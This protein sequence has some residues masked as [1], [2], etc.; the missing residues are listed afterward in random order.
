MTAWARDLGNVFKTLPA[1]QDYVMKRGLA[2]GAIGRANEVARDTYDIF[3]KAPPRIGRE[4]FS[5]LTTAGATVA[6][7]SDPRFHAAA[8]TTKRRI[9]VIGRTLVARGVITQA[10][11]DTYKDAYL[12][13]LYLKHLLEEDPAAF[14]VGRRLSKQGYVKRRANIPIDVREWMG[15]VKDPAFLSAVGLAVPLRDLAIIEFLEQ[16][17]TKR[18][19]VYQ[20]SL[21]N[22]RGQPVSV[23][24]LREK[25]AEIR[26][27][28]QYEPDPA[29]QQRM[30]TA[31]AQMDA[32]SAPFTSAG[33]RIPDDYKQLP[34]TKRYGAL[35]GLVV[36]KEIYNDL[37]SAFR[38]MPKDA[39]F[40]E[41]LF[42]VGGLGTKITQLWKMGKVALNPPSQVR[43]LMTNL[44]ML[45]LSGVPL[46]RVLDRVVAAASEM[47]SGGPHWQI[48]K[49][50][51]VIRGTFAANEL[52]EINRELL[53]LRAR[54]G[55]ALA[56]LIG[57][58]GKIGTLASNAYQ[59]SDTLFKVAKIIDAMERQGL[60]E[61]E[62]VR[63]SDKWIF[64]YSAVPPWVKY[65]RNAPIGVPFLTWQYKVIPRL[66]EV[67][68]TKPWRFLPWVALGYA[69][70]AMVKSQY[71]LDDDDLETLKLGM[72]R[73]MQRRGSVYVLPYQ[74]EHGRWVF[75]DLGYIFPW[76]I[77]QEVANNAAEG[78]VS[79]TVRALGFG[80]PVATAVTALMSGGIDPFTKRPIA[81][82]GDPAEVQ[83]GDYLAWI[84]RTAA[85]TWLTDIG[86]AQQLYDAVT[87]KTNRRGEPKLTEEQA[88]L[89]FLG[90]NLYPSDVLAQRDQNILSYK[91]E[92]DKARSRMTFRLRDQSLSEAQRQAII[93]D[94]SAEITRRAKNLTDYVRESTPSERLARTLQ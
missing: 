58:A 46:Y 75:L 44:I 5:F 80:G 57:L 82:E 20:D 65:L 22:Y 15:E 93:A 83:L 61:E 21:A 18:E 13:R 66:I 31:A 85:P 69:I 10:Q 17:A 45:Q 81:N 11:Y 26:K 36:R 92:L 50:Y 84:W 74:D 76:Q 9:D 37:V 48:A 70:S 55:G 8:A 3:V 86:A 41:S 77:I 79:G 90:I 68:A 51:G 32:A 1:W 43:N 89:R 49:K 42:G 78:S 19:W 60:S 24:W 52:F 25:A 33:A 67:A 7:I 91:A 23:W 39:S 29:A 54:Q 63:E 30:L 40:A 56:K 2:S 94:H 53:D 27:I 47:A 14:G 6:S 64:D 34:D 62:A 12:P 16:I 71:D 88:A 87:G 59:F 4:I 72:A 73:Y 28:A 38:M 35:R